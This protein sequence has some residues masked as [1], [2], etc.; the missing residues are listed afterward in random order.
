MVTEKVAKKVEELIEDKLDVALLSQTEQLK[1]YSDEIKTRAKEVINSLPAMQVGGN[2]NT[3]TPHA[4][5]E[6]ALEQPNPFSSR[7]KNKTYT[8]ATR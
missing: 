5:T 4:H 6:Q 1:A 2:G 8:D 3:A 7:V